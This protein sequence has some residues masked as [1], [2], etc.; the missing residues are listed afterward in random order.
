MTTIVSEE[1]DLTQVF[2]ETLTL[3]RMLQD[4]QQRKQVAVDEPCATGTHLVLVYGVRLTL[5]FGF[6]GFNFLHALVCRPDPLRDHFD[7]GASSFSIIQ[8]LTCKPF[9]CSVCHDLREHTVKDAGW[10][11]TD[12]QAFVTRRQPFTWV[13]HPSPDLAYNYGV[14]AMHTR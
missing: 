8:C 12:V 10:S 13:L 6:G 3:G 14:F 9:R 5:S 7:D 4:E 11:A 1:R 2:R